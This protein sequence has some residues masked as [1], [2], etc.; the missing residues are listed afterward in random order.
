MLPLGPA[1]TD[2]CMASLVTGSDD[3]LDARP[4]ISSATSEREPAA[5]SRRGK[6]KNDCKRSRLFPQA[7]HDVKRQPA[8][9][10]GRAD[11][12]QSYEYQTPKSLA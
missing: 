10:A 11:Q 6:P 3:A 7:L 1:D 9:G 5:A 8:R 2:A 12:V 4:M